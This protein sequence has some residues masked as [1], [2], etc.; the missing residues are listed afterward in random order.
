MIIKSLK[1]A[2][3]FTAGDASSLRE[4]FHPDKEPLDIGGTDLAFLC[5]VDPAW[6]AGD[7]EILTKTSLA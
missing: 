3:G 6:R 7:E 4:L 5:I 1:S 2:A